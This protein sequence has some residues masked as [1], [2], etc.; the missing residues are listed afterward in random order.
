MSSN[1]L[2]KNILNTPYLER[3]EYGHLL[4]IQSDF[5]QVRSEVA[6]YSGRLITDQ[7]ALDKHM[8]MKELL[9]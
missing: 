2:I 8:M 4:D 3:S 1:L 6:R 7:K 9:K 5:E